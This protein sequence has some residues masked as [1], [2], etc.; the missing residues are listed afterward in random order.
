MMRIASKKSAV[1]RVVSAGLAL[2]VAGSCAAACLGA[3]AATSYAEEA[4][5]IDWAQ[6]FPDEYNSY[7]DSRYE[8]YTDGRHGGHA[9][10]SWDM[11]H[12]ARFSLGCM[13]CHTTQYQ[14]I[15]DEF[16]EGVLNVNTVSSG[17]GSVQA[18]WADPDGLGLGEGDVTIAM[19]KRAVDSNVGCESCHD[20]QTGMLAASDELMAAAERGGIETATANLVCAQ[21][22]SAPDWYLTHSTTDREAMYTIEAGIEP[23]TQWRRYLDEGYVNDRINAQEME[24]NHFYGSLMEKSGATC[25]SCHVQKAVNDEGV[26]YTNHYFT[27][28]AVNPALYENCLSCHTDST[29]ED[30]MAA[31][32]QVQADTSAARE[33]A[34]SVLSALEV[35]IDRAEQDGTSA[36]TIDAVKL[37]YRQAQFYTNYGSDGSLGVHNIGN[38]AFEGIYD[39]AIA[40]ATQG[41]ELLG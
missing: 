17:A 12:S 23:E 5:A 29:A 38:A 34:R 13:T 16:G 30:M 22:H 18:E 15:V 32:E 9:D 6:Q 40:I 2:A 26:E 24:F 10:S 27:T 8:A 41:I 33:E 39:E 11:L 14:Q 37:L 20:A 3:Q 36:E 35:M 25:A 28:P 7:L 4:D 21:C 19:I 1:A 31:V